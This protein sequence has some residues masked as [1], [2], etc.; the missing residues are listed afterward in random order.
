MAKFKKGQSGNP[1]GKPPGT[2]NRLSATV[3]AAIMEAL[4]S[5]EGATEFFRQLK[6]GS[7]EDKRTF[8][9][10]CARL[11]PTEISGPDGLPLLMTEAP[12]MLEMARSISF[13][14]TRADAAITQPKPTEDAALPHLNGHEPINDLAK[15]DGIETLENLKIS[16]RKQ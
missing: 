1:A 6:N 9:Q 5:D 11:L 13:V 12:D 8:A 4:N 7:R 16:V 10:I 15:T 14:L 3:K 2:V